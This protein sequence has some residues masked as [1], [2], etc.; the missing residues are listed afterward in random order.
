MSRVRPLRVLISSTSMSVTFDNKYHRATCDNVHSP[1]R[2]V[3]VAKG[4]PPALGRRTTGGR[5]SGKF[6]SKL[7]NQ[8]LLVSSGVDSGMKAVSSYAV[9]T[10]TN[11]QEAPMRTRSGGQRSEWRDTTTNNWRGANCAAGR[12][13]GKNSEEQWREQCGV[14]S[15]VAS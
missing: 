5:F 14:Q 10:A 13:I 8:L 15:G 6:L 2:L 11:K 7:P 12:K 1:G 3:E 4:S 9:G